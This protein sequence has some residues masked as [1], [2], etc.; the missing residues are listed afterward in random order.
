MK[1]A[2]AM[3]EMQKRMNR[4][5]FGVASENYAD[6]AMGIDY[7]MLTEST[8]DLRKVVA[9]KMKLCRRWIREFQIAQKTL[10]KLGQATNKGYVSGLASS[11]NLADAQGIELISSAKKK[12]VVDASY[13]K[14]SS[15]FSSVGPKK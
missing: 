1:E 11:F 3:S 13:F 8:G 5:G 7:G 12:E 2:R 14:A 15:G 4:R 6:E 10:K 9:K